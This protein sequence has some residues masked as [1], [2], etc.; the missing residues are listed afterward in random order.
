M[1]YRGQTTEHTGFADCS[2]FENSSSTTF[3][4]VPSAVVSAPPPLIDSQP[5]QV[6]VTTVKCVLSKNKN[7]ITHELL[8]PIPT[9]TSPVSHLKI[10]LHLILDRTMSDQA[11]NAVSTL[12]PALEQKPF[13]MDFS[14]T[15]IFQSQLH[16]APVLS[17]QYLRAFLFCSPCRVT[18][19]VTTQ[20]PV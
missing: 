2:Y 8:K 6:L 19:W 12:N 10:P 15:L 14:R 3:T 18:S 5:T 17:S 9:F 1:N 7:K 13:H 11:R 4:A 16:S 20:Q